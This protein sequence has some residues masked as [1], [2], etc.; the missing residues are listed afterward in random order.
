M[1]PLL[2]AV[3][4]QATGPQAFSTG[5]DREG[6]TQGPLVVDQHNP[7]VLGVLLPHVLGEVGLLQAFV[8]QDPDTCLVLWTETHP[9]ASPEP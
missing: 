4:P 6:C 9:A 7:A 5:L 8:S 2:L 1:D 3:H